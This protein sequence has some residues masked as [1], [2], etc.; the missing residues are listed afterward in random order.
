MEEKPK[1]YDDTL[2]NKKPGNM[3]AAGFL[4]LNM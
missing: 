2:V 1:L 3:S 4:V